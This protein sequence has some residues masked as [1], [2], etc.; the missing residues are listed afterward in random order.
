[1]SEFQVGGVKFRFCPIPAGSFLMGSPDGS[2]EHYED[3]ARR[4]VIV[5]T[6]EMAETPVTQALWAAVNGNKP[7]FFRGS[8]Q[9]PVETV[10]YHDALN[11][12]SRLNRFVVGLEARLPTEGEW[13]YACRAGT[14]TPRYGDLDETAWYKDNSNNATQR[15]AQK[16]P[17]AFGLYDT[18]GDVWEWTSTRE[19][20]LQVI[21]GGSG[22][23]HS[24]SVR[25][26]ERCASFPDKRICTI[27]FRLARNGN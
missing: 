23:S 25:A 1:M 18:L 19:G 3:E 15:V 17:N 26:T 27:G 8:E 4:T 14:S 22:R 5:D 7:S 21:R 13:E 11:F 20:G 12:V 9:L 2:I 10:S 6:F 24:R 16:K